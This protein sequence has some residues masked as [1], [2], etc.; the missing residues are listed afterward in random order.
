MQ[1]YARND[2]IVAISTPLGFGGIGIVRLSGH[3]ALKIA[4]KIFI[5][6]P[7]TTKIIPQR[8]IFGHLVEIGNQEPLDDG[9]LIYFRGPHSYTKED[10]VELSLHGSPAVLEGALRSSIKAGARAAH[11]GEFTLRAFLN[12][13]YDIIQAE[14]VN[15]LI[16]A[17]SLEAAKLAFGQMDGKLS[18]GIWELRHRIVRLQADIEALIEFPEEGLPVSIQKISR[19]LTTIVRYLEKL[20]SSYNPGKALFEGVTLALVGKTNVGKSTLFNAILEEER[21]IVTPYP[22]TTRDYLRERI[23]IRSANFTLVDMAGLAKPRAKVEKAGIERGKRMAAQADGLMIILDISRKESRQDQALL[24]AYRGRNALVVFN[25]IDLQRKMNVG[26]IRQWSGRLPSVEI[27]ALK[28]KNIDFLKAAIYRLFAVKLKNPESTIF[29]LRQKSELEGVLKHCR[30]ARNML[31]T[32]GSEEISA[33]EIREAI[34]GI[35]RL[36]GEIRTDEVLEDIFSRFCV[37]K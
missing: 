9:Y 21:A 19:S 13:R 17:T 22:G 36:T 14:A 34:L 12:G 24:E 32:K 29:H 35:G 20:V 25:K 15:D 26:R 33:E 30:S 7:V 5:S 6:A 2:T 1:D 23:R 16:H 31:A 8:A 4:R 3:E 37:G 27:S 28:G 18:K 10:V 11:P